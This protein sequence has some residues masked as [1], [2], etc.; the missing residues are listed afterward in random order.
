MKLEID[1]GNRQELVKT[2]NE[3]NRYLNIVEF[4][5]AEFDKSK[6]PTNGDGLLPLHQVAES[7]VAA[8]R[9]AD[10]PILNAI[11]GLN[12]RF[13][14]SD[15]VIALGD[16]GKDSRGAIKMT[17]KRA[18]EAGTVRLVEAG[19][20]RRPSKYEKIDKTGATN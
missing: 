16:K 1:I 12:S 9:T 5:L 17:L 2:K 19:Q 14:T 20:G 8:W 11:Q 13:T 6:H 3:L 10:V 15:V 4:A 7:G 18:I